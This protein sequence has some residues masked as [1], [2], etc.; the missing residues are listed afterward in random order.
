MSDKNLICKDCGTVGKAS[1]L[2]TSFTSIILLFLIIGSFLANPIL[3]ILV[4]V[5]GII[6]SSTQ[7]KVKC[8]ACG[9]KTLIPLD[10][11]AGQKLQDEFK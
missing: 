1:R 10:S 2:S 11:P 7:S 4:L 9:S 8:T 5:I 6:Y 3:G